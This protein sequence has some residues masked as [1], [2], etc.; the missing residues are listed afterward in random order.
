MR[1]LAVRLAFYLKR[2]LRLLVC[3]EATVRTVDKSLRGGDLDP[4]NL[5]IPEVNCLLTFANPHDKKKSEV[6]SQK[7]QVKKTVKNFSCGYKPTK[8]SRKS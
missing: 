1:V 2:L 5:L 3:K 4:C 6:R 8:I 7:S